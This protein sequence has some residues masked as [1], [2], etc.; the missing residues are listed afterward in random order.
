MLDLRVIR[1]H[2]EILE[3]LEVLVQ[4]ELVVSLETKVL[5]V[6]LDCKEIQEPQGH[7]ET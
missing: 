2:Q 1:A 4:L 3:M 5:L 7:Q 6:M